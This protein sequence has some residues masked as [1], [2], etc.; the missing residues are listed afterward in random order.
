MALAEAEFALLGHVGT[1]RN[2]R[3]IVT[4]DL[5]FAVKHLLP[6]HVSLQVRSHGDS[7]PRFNMGCAA[8]TF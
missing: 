6:R 1:A 3:R 8:L 4:T 2:F 5:S 7:Q